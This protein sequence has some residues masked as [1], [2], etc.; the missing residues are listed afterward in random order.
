MFF[1]PTVGYRHFR[2]SDIPEIL[3]FQTFR[4]DQHCPK[5]TRPE[6]ALART[7]E[8]WSGNLTLVLVCVD[9]PL[10]CRSFL[11]GEALYGRPLSLVPRWP[12]FLR[13]CIGE[14][15]RQRRP[16]PEKALVTALALLDTSVSF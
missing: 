5:R 12:A 3:T 9:G 16:V 13:P 11:A 1:N 2:H 8:A 4:K 10:L 14:D 6:R 7:A 15:S